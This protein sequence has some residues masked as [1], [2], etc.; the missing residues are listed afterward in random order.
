MPHGAVHRWR[1]SVNTILADAMPL[2]RN[3]SKSKR[4]TTS[5]VLT[6][7]LVTDHDLETST[8]KWAVW[9]DIAGNKVRCPRVDDHG[10]IA[11]VLPGIHNQDD[12]SAFDVK[13]LLC[14]SKSRTLDCVMSQMQPKNT[15]ST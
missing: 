3:D 14:K 7:I 12:L 13:I 11:Y 5:N 10:N 9:D 1:E 6:L 4:P 8:L 15:Y 2:W